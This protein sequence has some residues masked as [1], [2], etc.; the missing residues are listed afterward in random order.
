MQ[1]LWW[2]DR[3]GSPP[4]WNDRY[5]NAGQKGYGKG[6]SKHGKTGWYDGPYH[7]N[8]GKGKPPIKAPPDYPPQGGKGKKNR[9]HRIDENRGLDAHL[10]N[11]V[12]DDPG[13]NQSPVPDD[14]QEI[15][16]ILQG[17]APWRPIAN[18]LER[19]K[20]LWRQGRAL[21]RRRLFCMSGAGFSMENSKKVFHSRN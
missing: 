18:G 20:Y 19:F 6:G 17:N 3:R 13:N 5:D 9:D 7:S 16:E 14:Y 10:P 11:E 21:L 15:K 1:A 12:P 8:K 2:Q 4:D